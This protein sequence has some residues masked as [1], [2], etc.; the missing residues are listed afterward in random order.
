MSTAN[1]P[2]VDATRLQQSLYDFQQRFNNHERVKK[3]IK[4]WNRF[5]QVSATDKCATFTLTIQDLMISAIKPGTGGMD[6]EQDDVITV[7]A[8]EET[9]VR[10][11]TGKYNP[12]H[13]VIDGAMAVYSDERDKVKLEAIAMVIWGL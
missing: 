2:V 3:L 8:S 1:M 7:E 9:L 13:A 12:A 11:F 6:Q 10:I 5:L 4:G